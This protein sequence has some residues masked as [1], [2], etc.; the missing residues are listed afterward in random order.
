MLTNREC[1]KMRENAFCEKLI[2][3][4][5]YVPVKDE[6]NK[7]STRAIQGFLYPLVSIINPWIRLL[8]LSGI[9]VQGTLHSQT[10]VEVTSHHQ[11]R[12]KLATGGVEPLV[13]GR[14][15]VMCALKLCVCYQTDPGKPDR[16]AA[17]FVPS[18]RGGT[19]R[20][21]GYMEPDPRPQHSRS[22]S[23]LT[24]FSYF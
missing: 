3:C 21:I 24:L 7:R 10:V 6:L 8:L 19:S 23:A 14:G 17:F 5:P 22:D 1:N 18:D 16:T 20:S 15:V 9:L 2:I 13:V 4:I 12:E 11:H